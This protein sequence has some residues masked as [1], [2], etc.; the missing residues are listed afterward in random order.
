MKI[1]RAPQQVAQFSLHGDEFQ[2]RNMSGLEL[3]E[4]VHVALIG[5]VVAEHR[6]EERQAAD[7]VASAELRYLILIHFDPQAHDPECYRT[8]ERRDLPIQ[9]QN[10]GTPCLR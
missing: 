5:E 4:D 3:H 6:S 10:R 8:T 9:K 7:V 1:H 2:P